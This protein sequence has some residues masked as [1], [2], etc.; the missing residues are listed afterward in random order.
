MSLSVGERNNFL[1]APDDES[2]QST[3]IKERNTREEIL[4]MGI[5]ART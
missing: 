1:C 2:S 5:R 3:A 4:A